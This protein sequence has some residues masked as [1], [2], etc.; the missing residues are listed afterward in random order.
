[1]LNI[2]VALIY[3]T[4]TLAL[5]NIMIVTLVN[6]NQ[7]DISSIRIEGCESIEIKRLEPQ[8]K[9]T[10]WIDIKRD[11]EINVSY[12]LNN[13]KRTENIIGYVSSGRGK[14]TVYEIGKDK[15]E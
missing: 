12:N 8:E 5:M 2:P 1:M 10:V 14:R 13:E 6:T 15:K 3:I 7:T 9:H 11:C 4:I